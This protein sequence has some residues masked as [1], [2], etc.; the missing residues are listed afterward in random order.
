MGEGRVRAHCDLTSK[1]KDRAA[2]G[3]HPALSHEYAGEGEK[4]S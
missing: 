3:P 1:L 2:A 4:I